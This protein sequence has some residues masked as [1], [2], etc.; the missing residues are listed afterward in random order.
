[1]KNTILSENDAKL[2]EKAI[3]QY[4]RILLFSDLKGIFTEQYT[5]ESAKNRIT[6][7]AKS[8][9]FRRIKRG[10]YL[11]VDSLSARSQN[12]S[13]LYIIANALESVSYVSLSHAL[14]YYQMFD[15]YDRIITSITTK[16]SKKYDFDNHTYNFSKIKK[17]LYFG[18]VE[19]RE[20]GKIVRIA[21]AEKALLD[22]LYLESSFAVASLVFEKIKEHHMELDL[23]KLQTYSEKFGLTMVRKVGF[24]LDTLNLNSDLCYKALGKNLG[25]SRLG[26]ETKVFNAKW[27]LY[28]D[29]RIIR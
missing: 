27:R 16:Y 2:I 7:L 25:N 15:Q 11:I 10:L 19:K 3:I 17:N 21:E 12:D 18:F 8:G 6:Q 4:G 28:Y 23:N 20:N 22:Y 29:D 14:N 26:S 5:K 1:M 24:M 9:W 13:S